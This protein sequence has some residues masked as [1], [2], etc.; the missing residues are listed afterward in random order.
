MLRRSVARCSATSLLRNLATP[1]LRNYATSQLRNPA[2][3]QLRNYATPNLAASLV[4][5]PKKND[6]GTTA[7]LVLRRAKPL[8]SIEHRSAVG[9]RTPP[10]YNRL[11]GGTPQGETANKNNINKPQTVIIMNIQFEKLTS[12]SE[13]SNSRRRR[14]TVESPLTSCSSSVKYPIYPASS[15]MGKDDDDDLNLLAKPPPVSPPPPYPTPLTTSSLASARLDPPL[16]GGTPRGSINAGR[17]PPNQ[18]RIFIPNPP[19]SLNR[20][21]TPLPILYQYTERFYQPEQTT[22]II[23]ILCSLATSLRC[24]LLRNLA[25]PQLSRSR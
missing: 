10:P 16:G 9:G 6:P 17:R 14:T 25:T 23:S 8:W 1:Q 19:G 15:L 3:P 4:K 22:Q 20:I 5:S 12:A 7:G 13:P 11:G 24:S 18:E 2:T 21:S